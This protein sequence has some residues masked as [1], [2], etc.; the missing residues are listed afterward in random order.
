LIRYA[1]SVCAFLVVFM[2]VSAR[3]Q[4]NNVHCALC[5]LFLSSTVKY[6]KFPC[7]NSKPKIRVRKGPL[8]NSSLASFLVSVKTRLQ[9]FLD[10]LT[11]GLCSVVQLPCICYCIECHIKQKTTT[12]LVSARTL[13]TNKN[14][15]LFMTPTCY[16]TLKVM[17]FIC[18][19]CTA[20]IVMR[21]GGSN[22]LAWYLSHI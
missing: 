10:N 17:H 20:N 8:K 4:F 11:A 13:I 9:S 7:Q 16:K 5:E 2:N 18:I 19:P 22:C 6:L 1:R 14:K 21:L 15:A 12:V 3:K